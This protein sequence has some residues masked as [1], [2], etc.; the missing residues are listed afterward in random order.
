MTILDPTSLMK[1]VDNINEM[2]LVEETIPPEAGLEATRWIASRQ[3]EKG[4]YRGMSAPTQSDFE[5]GIHVFTGERLA[6]ASARHVMGEEAARAA[7]LLGAQ[8]PV[9]R[10]AYE[11]A[12]GWM[13][14]VL[15]THHDG[16]FCCGRCTTAFWRHLWIGDFENKEAFLLKGLQ[17]MQDLRL[18]DGQWRRYPF[19][20]MVY[21][22]VD[23]ELEPAR[24]ELQ[25]ARPALERYLG[26]TRAGVFSRRRQVI[27]EQAL[28]LLA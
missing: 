24:T 18:G 25:Y 16:T 11:Q 23:L 9:V 19:F 28:G 6:S 26:H 15:N 4:S 21:T 1:T 10:T 3:G 14:E 8:D 13:H 27:L 17:G 2:L 20:Y 5:Q 22:L 12:I 7:W